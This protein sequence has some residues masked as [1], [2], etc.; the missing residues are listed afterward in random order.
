MARIMGGLKPPPTAKWLIK[1]L[2]DEGVILKEKDDS[3]CPICLKEY[4]KDDTLM[5]LPCQHI[6][7]PGCI[8][9]WLTKTRCQQIHHSFFSI[10][11][12]H[13]SVD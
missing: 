7:H 9:P 2:E 10:H 6:F 8:K 1:A 4:E 12:R 3:C 11:R 13:Y 5:K